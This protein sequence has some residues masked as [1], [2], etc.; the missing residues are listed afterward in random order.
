MVGGMETRW[1]RCARGLAAGLLAAV[2]RQRGWPRGRLRR[3]TLTVN[4]RGMRRALLNE[5]DTGR[6]K[7]RKK[8]NQSAADPRTMRRIAT[9]RPGAS[10]RVG[11]AYTRATDTLA[12]IAHVPNVQA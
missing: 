1:G 9:N 5:G 3:W 11:T 4:T 6:G 10:T 7:R 12:R 2:G 8:K